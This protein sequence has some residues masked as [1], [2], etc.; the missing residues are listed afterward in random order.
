VSI[1]NFYRSTYLGGFQLS[2]IPATP[3]IAESHVKSANLQSVGLVL[4]SV[5]LGAV[6]QLTIKAAVNEMGP[7]QLSA[8]MLLKMVSSPLLLIALGIYGVSAILWLLALMK[9]DLSFA[10]PFLSLTYVAVL[11]G[12]AVLFHERVTLMRIV[13]FIVIVLGLVIIT[14]GEQSAAQGTPAPITEE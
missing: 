13:G 8:Q 9:A 2:T 14:R 5:T 6:G 7:L 12:G 1:F 4:L 10:Y 11:T 3:H